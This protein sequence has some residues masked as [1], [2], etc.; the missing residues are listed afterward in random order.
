MIVMVT[1]VLACALIGLTFSIF[2]CAVVVLVTVTAGEVGGIVTVGEAGT[3]VCVGSGVTVRG[4][5]EAG[6]GVGEP[7]AVV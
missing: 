4:V 3:E 2:T 7:G 1:V 6:K 5:G